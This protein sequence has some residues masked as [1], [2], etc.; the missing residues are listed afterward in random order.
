MKGGVTKKKMMLN[1][2]IQRKLDDYAEAY[3]AIKSRIGID[4][5][6][7]VILQEMAKDARMAEIKTERRNGAEEPATDR[8]M[9]FLKKNSMKYWGNI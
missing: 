5:V 9:A 3:D 6:A 4:A 2:E 7:S 8:Q 1:D